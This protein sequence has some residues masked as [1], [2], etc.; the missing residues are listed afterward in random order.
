MKIIGILLV[1]ILLFSCERTDY[2]LF[3]LHNHVPEIVV[4]NYAEDGILTFKGYREWDSA[5][6][7]YEIEKFTIFHDSLLYGKQRTFYV[8][9]EGER[10]NC[11]GRF[12][13]FLSDG[14]GKLLT[15][16]VRLHVERGQCNK[17]KEVILRTELMLCKNL[18]P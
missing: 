17:H 18:Q 13:I 10:F 5:G 2:D 9:A 7:T 15:D 8:E 6:V 12:W 16:T 1:L 3:G 4:W 14:D 11:S